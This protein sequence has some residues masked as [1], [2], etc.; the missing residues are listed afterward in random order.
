MNRLSIGWVALF[1]AGSVLAADPD[2][3]G[4]DDYGTALI[5]AARPLHSYAVYADNDNIYLVLQREVGKAEGR[6]QW[7]VLNYVVIPQPPEDQVFSFSTCHWNGKLDTAVAAISIYQDD[8]FFGKVV[9]AWRANLSEGK[10]E[11]IQVDGIVCPN[12]GYSS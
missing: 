8:E 2:F 5:G 4:M 11:E 3:S 9:K 1:L 7:R 6:L 10:I 12:D